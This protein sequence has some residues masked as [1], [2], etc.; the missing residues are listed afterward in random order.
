MWL[1]NLVITSNLVSPLELFLSNKNDLFI[2][3]S[4]KFEI[5]TYFNRMNLR[6]D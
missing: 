2:C 5:Q 6:E 1:L 3:M 4:F